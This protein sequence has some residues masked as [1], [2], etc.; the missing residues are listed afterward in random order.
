MLDGQCT[1]AHVV[2]AKVIHDLE[3]PG[4]TVAGSVSGGA[5]GSSISG[6]PPPPVPDWKDSDS[7]DSQSGDSSK[8]LSGK[9]ASSSSGGYCSLERRPKNPP[10]GKPFA[11]PVVPPMSTMTASCSTSGYSSPA[12]D[13][14]LTADKPRQKTVIDICNGTMTVRE[15]NNNET[16]PS[17]PPPPPPPMVISSPAS[18]LKLSAL[19]GLPGLSGLSLLRR[20]RT[21]NGYAPKLSEELQG[22]ILQSESLVFLSSRELEA[23]HDSRQRVRWFPLCPEWDTPWLGHPVLS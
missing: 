8:T 15:V 17:P 10:I 20:A 22:A 18:G 6:A 19:S 1:K 14:T 4:G 11:C 16:T 23:R 13:V 9:R 2:D 3:S 21:K 12:L 7:E 5:G